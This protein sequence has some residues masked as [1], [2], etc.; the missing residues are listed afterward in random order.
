MSRFKVNRNGT[1][2]SR[3]ID[4]NL[5]KRGHRTM[6]A[7]CIAEIGFEAIKN[8][9]ISIK[10][11]QAIRLKI[12]DFIERQE[13]INRN[14]TREEEIDFA[15]L[16]KY[17]CTDLLKDVQILLFG[18]QKER[19]T[20][21]KTI[22]DKALLYARTHTNL[23][24]ARVNTMIEDVI[25]ILRSFY[26]SQINSQLKFSFGETIDAVNN[27]IEEQLSKQTADL[28]DIINKSIA[29]VEKTLIKE[30][31]LPHV[32][33]TSVATFAD[34]QSVI[35]REDELYAIISIL[36]QEK[37]A[38]LLSGFG[39]IGKTALTRV[40]YARLSDEFECIGWVEYHG[41]LKD[42]LLAS[43][44]LNDDI[45]DQ[46]KRWKT[47]STRLRTDPAKKI[48]FIDNVDRDV[49]QIQDPEKD[50]LL[51]EITGWHNMTIVLTSRMTELRGFR[52]YFIGSLG[53]ENCIQPCVDLFYYYYD[54]NEYQKAPKERQQSE[55]VCK[56]VTLA[57]FHTYAIELLARS[58]IYEH[59][60]SNYLQ[61]IEKLGFKFP[62]L[63]VLTGHSNDSATAAEQLRLLFNMQSR[64]IMERQI[65]WDFSILPEG[66]RLF[67]SEVKILLNY[68]ENHLDHLCK[69]GWL[70]YER[71]QGFYIHPLVKEVIH[72]DLK[73]GKAPS[74]TLTHLINLVQN[75]A[76]LSDHDTQADVLR[77]LHLVETA[78]KFT[79]FNTIEEEGSFYYHLGLIEYKFA[80]KRLT[81]IIYLEKALQSYPPLDELDLDKK[82]FVANIR[83]QIG[84]VKSTT[85]QYRDEAK[86]DLKLALDI[87]KTCENCEDK[88]AMAHDHLGYVLTDSKEM[89]GRAKH[90]LI[91]AL[92]MRRSFVKKD[93]TLLNRYAYSTTC[94][95]LGYLLFRSSD[96]IKGARKLLEKALSIRE[97]L[98]KISDEYATD[99]AWTSFNLGQLLSG[100]PQYC[101]EAEPYFRKSLDIRRKLDCQHPQMYTTNIVFTLV[102]L[103]KLISIDP[104][105]INEVKDLFDE[106]VNLKSKIDS[107]HTGFFSDE[108]ELNI[109]FLSELLGRQS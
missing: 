85:H 86:T 100:D 36:T 72:F 63:L 15:G 8:K 58:A 18:D 99:V 96:K 97:Q 78:E 70:R 20:S 64:S 35:H 48:L 92:K 104:K 91:E 61:K 88:V 40:L 24:D 102:S 23:S 66:T 77:K 67:S 107:D 101:N 11:K 19:I 13:K 60:L 52:P 59:D 27:S 47:I 87:W 71:H 62:T 37:T 6:I 31:R 21:K 30:E 76:L 74:G 75:D 84:Y 51:Q 56:L 17:M 12:K 38:L 82:R 105:R 28:T 4:T 55:D 26:R 22:V 65:L 2:K 46:E 44:D 89:Y 69:D 94:D 81:S 33:T 68:T 14:C 49:M 53:T 98:Y 10:Q 95:N 106:A 43:V 7:D 109:S 9:A 54:K 3:T 34:E 79:V 41:N 16:A 90:H 29:L 103:A 5:K 73:N 50:L 93:P 45:L 42:S 57:G 83:Y 1:I 25:E 108:I 80:R 32:L 39:G